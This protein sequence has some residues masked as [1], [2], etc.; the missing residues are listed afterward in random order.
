[1]DA[2]LKPDFGLMFWTTVNF[3]ILALLLAKFAWKPLVS[4]LEAREKKISDDV[5][6]AQ[7][8][9]QAA[10]K[11]KDDLQAQMDKLAKESSKRL[12]EARA[13]GEKRK[14]EMLAQA[15]RQAEQLMTQARRQIEAETTKAVECIKKDIAEITLLA[16]K[17]IIGKDANAKTSAQMVEDLLADLKVK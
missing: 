8:A 12:Y 3:V 2:L 6:Q 10:E 7:S 16:V 13:L 9:R 4:A 11:I 1:M 17:K 5:A 15:K 14:E